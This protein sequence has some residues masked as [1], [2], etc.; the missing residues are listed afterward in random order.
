MCIRDRVRQQLASNA[1]T[2]SLRLTHTLR[3]TNRSQVEH[4]SAIYRFAESQLS[5]KRYPGGAVGASAV[6]TLHL[7]AGVQRIDARGGSRNRGL[8]RD[9]RTVLRGSAREW[10]RIDRRALRGGRSSSCLLYTSGL[11]REHL[12]IVAAHGENDQVSGI[13]RFHLTR[14]Q[15]LSR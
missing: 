9:H 4:E 15:L 10:E 11:R 14:L 2:H 13:E 6:R 7:H 3:R 1:V 5:R 12:Q 8:Y